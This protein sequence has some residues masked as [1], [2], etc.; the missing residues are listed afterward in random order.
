MFFIFFCLGWPL[1]R[2]WGLGP[3]LETFSG[4]LW[5]HLWSWKLSG[6][7]FGCICVLFGLLLLL[8]DIAWD[9]IL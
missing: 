2:L 8:F 5:W 9:H 4:S 3:P 6:A 7:L 1:G